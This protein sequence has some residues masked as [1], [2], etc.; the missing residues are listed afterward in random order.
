MESLL[1]WSI[2]NTPE[3][4]A[5]NAPS[6][7]RMKELDPE[8]IDM[9]LGKSDAVVMKVCLISKCVVEL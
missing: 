3:D 5:R 7:E 4:R 1:K 8:I 6:A 2:E 9:I